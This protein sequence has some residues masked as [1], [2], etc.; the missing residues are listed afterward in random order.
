MNEY[1]III[2]VVLIFI[3]A[4]Y[5]FLSVRSR[6]TETVPVF[7]DDHF[8]LPNIT[9]A[10]KQK[11]NE[12]ILDDRESGK[13][14]D[15][16]RS[17]LRARLRNAVREACQG[18]MGDR[19]FLKDHIRDILTNDLGINESS[20]RKVFDF[21]D[22]DALSARDLFGYL[23]AIYTRVFGIHVF[24]HLVEDF[25]WNEDRTDEKGRLR[26]RIDEDMVRTAF[27]DCMYEGVYTDELEM[28]TQRCYENLY[29]HDAADILIMDS[30]ID[31]VSGGTG[32]KTRTE[33]NYLE[34]LFGPE[35]QQAANI[36][37]TIY[38]V[39]RGRLIHMSFLSFGRQENLERVIKNIYRYNARTTLSKRNPVLQSSMKNNSRVMVARPPVSD[40]WTFYVRKFASSDA[41]SIESLLTDEG[42]E[43]VICLLKSIV[44]AE[45]N[46]VVSGNTGGGKT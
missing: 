2:P 25:S 6:K 34:E 22:P 9:E 43:Y 20:I 28:L 31:G 40:G 32:G 17:I 46:F 29:G 14:T 41:G 5:L 27:E 12:R 7:G 30:D 16:K 33:Y 21:S 15:I 19:E 1:L 36:W 23:Y 26:G 13:Q 18:D 4:A 35:K 38:C 10:V 37:D 8:R 45:L 11:L 24:T 44:G 3:P 39:Y 42:S